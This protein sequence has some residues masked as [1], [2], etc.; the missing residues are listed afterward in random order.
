MVVLEGVHLY[1]FE[2]RI[3]SKSVDLSDLNPDEPLFQFMCL[4]GISKINNLDK[5]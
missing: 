4:I 5:E 2:Q 1:V 3:K